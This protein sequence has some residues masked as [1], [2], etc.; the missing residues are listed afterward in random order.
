MLCV[1]PVFPAFVLFAFAK[2]VLSETASISLLLC[3]FVH[4]SWELS[5]D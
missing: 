1:L 3:Y 4:E 2:L 5:L